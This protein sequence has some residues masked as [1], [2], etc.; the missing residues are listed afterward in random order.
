VELWCAPDADHPLFRR[1]TARFALRAEVQR[2]DD[3][4]ARM[5]HAATSALANA[6]AVVL[7]GT[8]CPDLGPEYLE[9]AL[10]LLGEHAVVLGPADDGGYVM[11]GIG[12]VCGRALPR[13]FEAMPWG[14][15]RIAAITRQRLEASGMRWAELP[16]LAD[17]DRPEDL[18]RFGALASKTP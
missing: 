1:L 7:I 17:L 4:G 13:L 15:D 12:K 10:T 2:G 9:Q 16:S 18:E 3:L 14:S 6:D 5:L 8:D 11:L